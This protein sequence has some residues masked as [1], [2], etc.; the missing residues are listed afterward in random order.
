LDGKRHSISNINSEKIREINKTTPVVISTGR[1]FGPKVKELMRSLD[2]E[3]AICQ[4]GAVIAN[5][6][7]EVLQEIFMDLESVSLIKK[8]AKKHRLVIVPNSTYKLYS[9]LTFLK[10]LVLM[11]PKHYFKLKKF[12]TTEQYNKIVLAGCRRSRLF[13]IFLELKHNFP[14]LS[15]KTSAN[16]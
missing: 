1:S 6:K 14:T 13:K 9:N 15:I 16:D 12:S 11:N 7:N 8:I 5:N 3:Y 4:N 10:P 2:L